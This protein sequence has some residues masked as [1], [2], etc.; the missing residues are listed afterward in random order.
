MPQIAL[1]EKWLHEAAE[2]AGIDPAE[3]EQLVDRVLARGDAEDDLEFA[4]RTR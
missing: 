2:R 3:A 1:I 4:R